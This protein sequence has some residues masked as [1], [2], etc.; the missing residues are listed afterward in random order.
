MAVLGAGSWGTAL[1]IL[2]AR[3]GHEVRLWARDASHV[4]E[5]AERRCNERMLPGFE[6]PTDLQPHGNAVRAVEGAVC[7]VLAVPTHAAGTVLAGLTAC[8]FGGVVSGAKGFDDERRLMH[9]L[10]AETLGAAM[11]F[12]VFSG[13]TFAAEIAAGFPAAVTLASRDA[14][15]GATV[16]A[17]FRNDHLRV[18]PSDDVAGVELAGAVKNVLA[19][20][21]GIVDGLGFGANTRAALITRGLA[22]LMR[23]GEHLGGRRETFMGLAGLGDLVLTCTDDKSRNR[24]FGLALAAGA[25]SADAALAV[26][27]VV[28][29]VR[30]ARATVA[31]ARAARIEMP[32]CEQVLAVIDGQCTP[33]E[34]LTA[35]LTRK[36]RS[37][38]F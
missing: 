3:N 28:E 22:E 23:F 9:A 30:A 15:F 32:I 21:A 1:A 38:E 6:F 7:V 37:G 36:P 4:A 31:L 10:V 33:R 25:T 12:A 18:Y 35:L 27:Q 13:P 20:A 19:I 5:L 17:L 26:G 16:S 29:G 14:G 8:T 2:L 34:A 11:P 24:R